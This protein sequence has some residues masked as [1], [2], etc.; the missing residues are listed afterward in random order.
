LGCN[1]PVSF[2]SSSIERAI[3]ERKNCKEPIDNERTAKLV[4]PQC[5]RLTEFNDFANKNFCDTSQDNSTN[6]KTTHMRRHTVIDRVMLFETHHVSA[7]A[8]VAPAR[9]IVR[10]T[11]FFEN[12]DAR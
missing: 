1:G 10:L 2:H 6:K 8:A 11:W 12:P 7:I 5:A 3:K 9:C 4:R